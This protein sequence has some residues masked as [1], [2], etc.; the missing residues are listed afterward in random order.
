MRRFG[1]WMLLGC[2]LG[3]GPARAQMVAGMKIP[4][5]GETMGVDVKETKNPYEVI[6]IKSSAP[7]SVLWPGEQASFTFQLINHSKD[8]IA[9]TGKVELLA[10]GTKGR[11]ND[12]WVPIM[13]K[14]ADC[15]KTPV[16]V[17]LPA[18]GYQTLTVTPD[19]PAALGP[20]AL[21][22]DLGPAGRRFITSFVRTF[23]A[24][25]KPVQFP[26][27][28][29]DN[30]E[31]ALLSRLGAAPN[32]IGIGYKVSTDPDYADWYRRIG[33]QLMAFKQA[34]LPITVE[35]GGGPF[36][37]PCQPLGRE[38]PWLDDNDFMR[39]TKFDL[40]WLPSYDADFKKMVKQIALDYGWP[41]GPIN[42]MK[43]WN[44]PWNGIS[45]SG[46]GADDL[47]YR[48]IFTALAQGVEEA[49][50]EGGVQ[51]LLGGCDSSS[52]TFDKFFGDGS[53]TFLK[54]LD[55]CSIHYQGMMA[56]TTVKA[57]VHRQSPN[58][59]VR[60]WDT[61]SW[62]A[63]TDDRVA[64]VVATNLSTG[65]DRAVGVY[66]GNIADPREMYWQAVDIFG[67]DGKKQ[68]IQTGHTWPVAASVGA[69]THFIGERGFNELL[70]KNGLP[71]VMVFHGN[72]A[73]N[74]PDPAKRVE[75]AED[76]TVVVVGDIGE[77]FGA[78]NVLFRTA[79]GF[80]E[81]AHRKELQRQLDALPATAPAADRA[82]LQ[83]ALDTPEAL[84]D[85]TMTLKSSRRYSLYD[86]YGN[87]VPAKSGKITIPLDH[88][89]FFLRG[90]GKPGSL[91]ALLEA[92]RTARIAGIEPL[93]KECQDLTARIEQKPVL[94][95]RLT[96]VLNRPISGILNV[97]LGQLTLAAPSQKVQ[98]AAGETK[99][100]PIQVA[101][102]T[103]VESNTYLLHLAYDA[104]KDGI[105]EHSEDLHV[106][107]IA[108]RTI[109]VDGKLDDWTGIPAQTITSPGNA[110]P[111]LMEFAWQ[112]FKTFDPK[113]TAG[114]AAGWLAYDQD[115]L[116]FAA[117]VAD[118]TP[119]EGMVR[120]ATRD[121]SR[122]FYPDV[123]HEIDRDKTFKY[124]DDDF[125]AQPPAWAV[126]DKQKY[127]L[128]VPGSTTERS[129]QG[130][131]P[132]VK[133]M[134][135]DLSLPKDA[136]TQV[137]VY[138]L[139]RSANPVNQ[140]N[141]EVFNQA[142]PEGARLSG[143]WV[144]ESVGTGQY[145]V[146]ELSGDVRLRVDTERTTLTVA[147]IFFDPAKSG[148]K[149][150]PDRPA[151]IF[152]KNDLTTQG[153]WQGTYGT[154]G[155]VIAGVP[156]KLPAGVTLNLRTDDMV[157]DYQWPDGV[158]HFTYRRDPDLPAGNFPNHDNIQIA[159]NVLP[160]A[161]KPWEMNPPGTMPKYTGYWDTDYEYALNPVATKYGG[162]TE[163]WPL[164]R[165]DLPNKHYYPHSPA[166][167]KEGPVADGKLV[168]T[169]DA[170]TRI[171]E[172]AIPWREL[173]EVKQAM[174]AGR[175]IKFSFRSND[176]AGAG[177]MELSRG[178]SVAKRNGSFK[179][180]WTEHWAN[181]LE[182]AFEK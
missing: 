96:N 157:K 21:V 134:A 106:N 11:P 27:L 143:Q 87:P 65:H 95:L 122:Y 101:T 25:P 72:L 154:S 117:K 56:P 155:Y 171:V 174:E 145:W 60:I 35:F 86:F 23:K 70:F 62:V 47:R 6:F 59:R 137:A 93:A 64:A 147:G 139:D 20:Y 164:R 82:K 63:N 67:E 37:H 39:D 78:N 92:L 144:R 159:F 97:T 91:A 28:C 68:R 12:I 169:R 138:F 26:Q 58:G 2:T 176:N 4:E 54:W 98:F 123:A 132:A 10:F 16:V 114:Y 133:R 18:G 160:D 71:W 102:G 5:F 31:V 41:K 153:N 129:Q 131:A 34:G 175:T 111:T 165:P 9:T 148:R 89:G 57:W 77:E 8:E 181:E 128:Q 52:N 36:R 33:E 140:T 88:R 100:I 30:G 110:A 109:A 179:V 167:P 127:A 151:S 116:Y 13:Y 162:G 108:H 107:V 75:D 45:I 42:G 7:A 66:G 125:A 172:C 177:C 69:T 156:P 29:L 112:P 142:T 126:A 3:T 43:L 180:D 168:I 46:W 15:G 141:F 61:E 163:I 84:S 83:K 79:R 113:V 51:V 74:D 170:N 105:S 14:R 166:S 146:G 49:R 48:E 150:S 178:R 149:V 1:L 73:G 124:T 85:A 55:F 118:S 44:E 120:Y 81:I 38:R 32:R 136:L 19:T 130:W 17:K 103:S 121:E 135:I 119:D 24:D 152:L 53:T 40:A 22:L 76:G 104:G 94:N 90:D 50:Q 115:A 80:A 173:P 161:D 158:R 182:F 99:T